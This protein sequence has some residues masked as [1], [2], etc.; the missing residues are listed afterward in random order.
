[1]ASAPCIYVSALSR[2]AAELSWFLAK[3]VAIDPLGAVSKKSYRSTTNE[4]SRFE[5]HFPRRQRLILGPVAK[6]WR[7]KHCPPLRCTCQRAHLPSSDPFC[8][9]NL[10]IAQYIFAVKFAQFEFHELCLPRAHVITFISEVERK[11]RI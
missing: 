7:Q 4:Q 5:S 2:P 11:R 8:H 9:C 3:T 6:L 1:M 10:G